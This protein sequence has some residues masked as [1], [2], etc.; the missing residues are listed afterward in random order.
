MNLK[1]TKNVFIIFHSLKGYDS[2][3]I[4]NKTR[5]FNAKVDVMPNGLEKYMAF[6]I[7]KSLVFIDS[8]QFMNSSLEILV[9]NLSDDAFKHLTKEFISEN[10]KLLRQKDAYPYED[11][12]NFEKF[13]E[14]K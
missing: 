7:N 3:L 11:M 9:K 8:K 5:K 6:T 12:D 1:L 10:F 2:H 13:S 14:K 4:M